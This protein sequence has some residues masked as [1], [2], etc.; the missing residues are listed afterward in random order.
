MKAFRR[1]LLFIAAAGLLGMSA[2]LAQDYPSRPVRIVVPFPAG[3]PLDV[4]ARLLAERM[5]APL[6][7]QVIVDNRPGAGGLIGAEAVARAA[8]DGHTLL[9]TNLQILTGVE[10]N[11]PAYDFYQDLV[12]VVQFAR[13]L[14]L[15]WVANETVPVKTVAEFVAY[16]RAHPGQVMMAYTGFSAPAYIFGQ[17]LGRRENIALTQV[18]YKGQTESLGDFLSGRIGTMFATLNVV[19]EGVKTGKVQVLAAVGDE[20]HPEAPDVPTL[21]QAGQRDMALPPWTGL[22]A[23]ARTPRAALA[24]LEQAVAV[25]L[26]APDMAERMRAISVKPSYL[27]GADFAAQYARDAALLRRLLQDSGVVEQARRDAGIKAR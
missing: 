2:C 11:P 4:L 25:A 12:P 5:R 26:Q 27:N 7:Q 23:P 18:A 15:M 16:A 22:A 13:F 24:R 21:A 1:K 9:L 3:G 20:R 17:V 10:L 19:A 14:P 6:G 8:P